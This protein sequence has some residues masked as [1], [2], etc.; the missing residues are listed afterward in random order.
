MR[1]ADC[2]NRGDLP[3]YI[4]IL[5]F[6]PV[7][8]FP[9][10]AAADAGRWAAGCGAVLQLILDARYTSAYTTLEHRETNSEGIHAYCSRS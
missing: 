2:P 5:A 9:V 8:A 4:H 6:L 1:T 3:R 10:R 7:K